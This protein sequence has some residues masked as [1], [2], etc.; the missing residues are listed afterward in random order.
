M[1]S[2]VGIWDLNAMCP[3]QAFE[4][5]MANC[6]A[7][8]MIAGIFL[9]SYGAEVSFSFQTIHG[10]QNLSNQRYFMGHALCTAS[11]QGMSDAV[12]IE[13]TQNG[14]SFY[15]PMYEPLPRTYKTF[16]WLEEGFFCYRKTID[17]DGEV[18]IRGLKNLVAEQKISLGL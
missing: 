18:S 9:R 10:T 4:T 13:S 1:N 12:V 15:L 2:T 7:R 6:A 3:T 17:W 14:S 5:G 16:P 8:A 11:V